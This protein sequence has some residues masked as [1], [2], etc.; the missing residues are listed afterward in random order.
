MYA[1]A[2]QDVNA[3]N[4]REALQ[5]LDAIDAR[6]PTWRRRKISAESP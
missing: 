4:Y 1:A 5:K 2:A 6:Q 3:G